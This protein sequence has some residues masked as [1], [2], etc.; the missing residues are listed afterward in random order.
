MS[1]PNLFDSFP[2]NGRNPSKAQK[3]V[4][5]ATTNTRMSF[6]EENR[7]DPRYHMVP[8]LL[9]VHCWV[10]PLITHQSNGHPSGSPRRTSRRT[11]DVKDRC[12]LLSSSLGR[13]RKPCSCRRPNRSAKALR[14]ESTRRLVQ[15]RR[16]HPERSSQRR[17][18]RHR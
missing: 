6:W 9:F 18:R 16:P 3:H 13:I 11:Y 5:P 10:S 2:K 7:L 17:E 12:T 15:T 8:Y 1:T 14:V 4:Q